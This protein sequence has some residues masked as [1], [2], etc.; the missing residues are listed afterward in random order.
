MPKW[1]DNAVFY[2]IYPQSFNDTNGD[3]IG[4]IPGI[5][6]KLG[7]IKEL[8][9]NALWINPWFDS[10][11]YDAGYDV[12]DFY[13]VAPR[14][15]NNEDAHRLFQEAHA[16]GIHVLLD[17]VAGHTSIEHEW[18][19]QSMQYAA[20][21]YS[22]R[23]IWAEDVWE[24][25]EGT[26]GVSGSIA[27]FCDR[28][29]CA[30]N[31][32][33][34][35]PALNYGFANPSQKW[36]NVVDSPEAIA[37]RE[38]L[39][40]IMFFWLGM[41]CDGFRVDMAGSLVKDDEGQEETIK[42]WQKIRKSLDEKFPE[43]AMISEWGDPQ[44][45]LRAGFD[46]DFLLHFGPTKYLSLFRE[47]PFFAKNKIGCIA[48][49]VADYREMLANK[50]EQGLICIPSSNHDMPRIA[51]CLD[52]EELK[53]A[54]AF[55]L[56]MP[57]APFIYYGDEIGMRYLEDVCPVEGGMSRT[58]SRSPMQWDEGLNAGF[59]SGHK[60]KLYIPIDTDNQRPTVSQQMADENS[61]WREIQCLIALRAEHEVL[62]SYAAIEFLRVENRSSPF[63]YRRGEGVG[64]IIIVLNPWEE[65]AS[66]PMDLDGWEVL[67][68]IGKEAIY[69]NCILQIQPCSAMFYMQR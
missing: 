44:R 58:G 43:T 65:A 28:G 38:A 45:A 9:C 55:I 30:V 11:F 46:M 3:G 34:T 7:Y 22:G 24:R 59:S 12:R 25:F 4:D 2:E 31:F 1:L 36:Q 33:S 39:L 5:I 47:E 51:H 16:R 61:L 19:R 27:G 23:Y 18:F 50:P 57:G 42:L 69:S 67:H 17:L 32:Y 64:S 56:S 68:C 63:I 15:G 14:Y 66:E 54:F 21:E 35:Q 49:F 53:L 48:D 13:K 26:S 8:G 52:Q 20:N 6:E 62:Q 10:P 40:D 29:S 37:T 41:G 60:S